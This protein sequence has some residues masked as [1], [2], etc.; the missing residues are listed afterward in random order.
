MQT[1]PYTFI[2]TCIKKCFYMERD[3]TNFITAFSTSLLLKK[4][5]V[6]NKKIDFCE[7]SFR[8]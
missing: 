4:K 1:V 3:K 5:I 6:R 7:L 2:N 8:E